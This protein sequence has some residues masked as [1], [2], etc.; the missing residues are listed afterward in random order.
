[1]AQLVACGA[2]AIQRAS[3]QEPGEYLATDFDAHCM[4]DSETPGDSR[5][6]MTHGIS[7]NIQ[8]EQRAVPTKTRAYTDI[9]RFLLAQTAR[10][11][12][13]DCGLDLMGHLG[14]STKIIFSLE[15]G[16]DAK[17]RNVIEEAAILSGWTS[18]THARE[19]LRFMD[20]GEA[21]ARFCILQYQQSGYYE[22]VRKYSFSSPHKTLTI[23]DPQRS[24]GATRYVICDAG[25][26]CSHIGTFD[27]AKLT[28]SDEDLNI[29]SLGI[30]TRESLSLPTSLYSHSNIAI[31]T[32]ACSVDK[33]FREFLERKLSKLQLSQDDINEYVAAGMLDFVP[34]RRRFSPTTA[35]TR[36]DLRDRRF[37]NPAAGLFKG[38]F[39]LDKCIQRVLIALQFA[40]NC[41]PTALRWNVSSFPIPT[42]L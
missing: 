32:S 21:V 10:Q 25:E 20:A 34:Q 26:L 9:L 41:N 7:R 29:M 16:H 18:R 22:H 2:E 24:P 33:E 35:A 31:A 37:H 17:L 15:P 36:I 5:Q 30:N 12:R 28:A 40:N 19:N 4:H 23:D 13:E 3:A 8:S 14:N 27:I 38:T 1:M 11:L 39:D 42:E 6:G